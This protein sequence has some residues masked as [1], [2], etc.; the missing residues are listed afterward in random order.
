[1][2]KPIK[3]FAVE[4]RRTGKKV[5]SLPDKHIIIPAEAKPVASVVVEW[6]HASDQS[7]SEARRNADRLFAATT[8]A[9]EAGDGRRVLPSLDEPDFIAKM[10]QEEEDNRPRRGRKPGAGLAPVR[11]QPVRAQAD[12]KAPATQQMPMRA[13]PMLALPLLAVPKN[14]AGYVHGR[15]YARYAKRSEPGLGQF[16]RKSLKPAW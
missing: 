7:L 6:P 8:H 13:L 11:R 4:L 16:W 15:I 12:D 3:P 1:M 14:I 9:P 5:K 10:L 2:K